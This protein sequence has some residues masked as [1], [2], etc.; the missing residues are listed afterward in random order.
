MDF[1]ADMDRY[2]FLLKN[3]PLAAGSD[4]IY[5]HGEKEFAKEKDFRKNGVPLMEPVVRM[6]QSAG[7][8]AGVDFNLEVLRSVQEDI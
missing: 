3:S 2:I 6:L 1:K 5:I 4:R 8:E 7:K